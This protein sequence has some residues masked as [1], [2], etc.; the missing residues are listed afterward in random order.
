MAVNKEEQTILHAAYKSYSKNEATI[1]LL[2]EK[3]EDIGLDLEH[4]DIYGR[5]YKGVPEYFYKHL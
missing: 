1:K 5:S 2:L 3:A 4:K